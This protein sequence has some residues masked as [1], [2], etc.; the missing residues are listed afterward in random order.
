VG[1]TRQKR[2]A[3]DG[4]KLMGT[5]FREGAETHSTPVPPTKTERYLL[6][7][8]YMIWGWKWD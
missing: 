1:Q 8:S 5:R 2:K 3:L 7:R 6:N 4:K